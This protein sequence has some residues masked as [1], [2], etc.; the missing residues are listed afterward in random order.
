MARTSTSRDQFIDGAARLFRQ[1]GY[2]GTGLKDITAESGAPWGSLYHHFPGG[3]SQLGAEAIRHS[4]D[5]YRRL[6]AKVFADADEPTEAVLRFFSLAA[7]AL[8]ASDFADGCP[9]ATTALDTASTN[10][11]VRD[12]CAGVFQDWLDDISARLEPGVDRQGIA[13]M[14]LAA[15]E[16]AIILSRSLRS[17]QPLDDV[18]AQLRALLELRRTVARLT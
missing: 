11:D 16:G 4:G 15:L 17:R 18:A 7:E 14:G 10:P 6:I 2:N 8:E 12:A 13:L 5:G 1:R 9:I 3:K